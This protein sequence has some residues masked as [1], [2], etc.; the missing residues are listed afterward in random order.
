MEI[1]SVLKQNIDTDQ[2]MGQA[3]LW[4]RSTKKGG[5]VKTSMDIAEYEQSDDG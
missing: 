4:R 3:R 1:N 2:E 5:L